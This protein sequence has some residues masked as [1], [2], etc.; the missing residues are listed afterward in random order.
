MSA[1]PPG[2]DNDEDEV[3]ALA[4]CAFDGCVVSV[5]IMI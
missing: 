3:K 4:C 2:N 1:A 5:S